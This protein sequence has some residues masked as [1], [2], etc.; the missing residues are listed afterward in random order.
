[1]NSPTCTF[2]YGGQCTSFFFFFI[3]TSRKRKKIN[4]HVL[5]PIVPKAK[6]LQA[7]VQK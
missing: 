6:R 2:S 3:H 5:N 4:N 7:A 1:M